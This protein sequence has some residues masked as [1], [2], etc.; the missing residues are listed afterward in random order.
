MRFSWATYPIQGLHKSR[1]TK[2]NTKTY[3]AHTHT[4]TTKKTSG[5]IC[6][7]D[8]KKVLRFVELSTV[9]MWISLRCHLPFICLLILAFPFEACYFSRQKK[10]MCVAEQRFWINFNTI[11]KMLRNFQ[12]ITQFQI[13]NLDVLIPPCK[14]TAFFTARY[15]R[16]EKQVEHSFF[17]SNRKNKFNHISVKHIMKDGNY[18]FF[19]LY[20]LCPHTFH[21]QWK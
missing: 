10:N 9:N 13:S 1:R 5:L 6:S 18:A 11:F 14:A 2:K 4:H 16:T 17:P 15:A 12:P 3:N 20:A 21:Q 19:L 7:C 8:K